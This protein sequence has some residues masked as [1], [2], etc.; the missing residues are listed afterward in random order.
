MTRYRTFHRSQKSEFQA[1]DSTTISSDTYSS[2]NLFLPT[3]LELFVQVLLP[4]HSQSKIDQL[5]VITVLPEEEEV[6]WLQITMSDL[7]TMKVV[8]SL[9]HLLKQHSSIALGHT[10]LLI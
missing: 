2:H 5:D 1:P 7:T 8:Y 9:H 10:P 6:L 3:L 4:L